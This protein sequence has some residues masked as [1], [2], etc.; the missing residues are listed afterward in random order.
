M[1]QSM[2]FRP[3]HLE[4]TAE[5]LASS[6][7]GGRVFFLPGSP[8]RAERIASH[9]EGCR[10]HPSGRGHTVY[11]GNLSGDG[12]VVEVGCVST[13]MGCPSVGIIV[14]ELVERGVRRLI[15]VGS[16]GG[17]QP[18]I[19]VGDVVIATGGVRD[20][21]AS[22]AFAPIEFP[23]VAS[24]HTTGALGDAARE[25][26]PAGSYH[27]GIIHSKDSL[28]GREFAM[29]PLADENERYMRLLRALGCVGSEMESSHLFVLARGL[30]AAVPAAPPGED[31]I[32]AACVCGVLGGV[33]GGSTAEAR[34]L[35]EVRAIDVALGAARRLV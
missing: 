19:A 20:E 27:F 21:G 6:Q 15:R 29:G 18:E 8:H 25:L 28:H 34:E 13:G 16:A 33:V 24:W 35:A 2:N 32:E 14:T 5:D 26:L 22:L 31:P 9:F 30:G 12:G 4:V 1:S 3:S 10:T 17:L 23:A 7:T 11:T